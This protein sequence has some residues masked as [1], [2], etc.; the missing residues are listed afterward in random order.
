ML[1]ETNPVSRPGSKPRVCLVGGADIDK[2]LDLMTTL[3]TEYDFVGVGTDTNLAPL[4]AKCGFRFRSYRMSR[5]AAPSSDLLAT[6]QLL[7]IFRSERPAIVHTF[8]TKPGVWGRIAARTAGVPV[9]IGTIPG[10]GSLYSSP[11][12]RGRVIRL[13]YQPLQRFAS[14]VST[15]TVFQ[16]EDDAREFARLGVVAADRTTIVP[17][18][19]VRTDFFSAGV[20]GAR[21]RL[22]SRFGFPNDRVVVLMISRILR[23]KGVLDFAGAA[24]AVTGSHQEALFVLVGPHDP[25]SLDALTPSELRNLRASVRWLGMRDDVKDLLEA[26]D[27][28]VF[29][30]V[31]REGIPRVLLEAASM[32]LPIVG[33]DVPGSREVIHDGKNG[34]LIQ[35]GDRAA[36]SLAIGMLVESQQLRTQ[37]GQ[38]SRQLAVSQFDLGVVAE[39]TR[40]V[41]ERALKA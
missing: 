18:S 19:G 38:C 39:A 7:L 3:A 41:Y 16:N 6:L 15:L 26:A 28:F 24:Q 25:Q 14:R 36:M 1:R 33:M 5:G 34:F 2:R 13:L 23:S 10:L 30:S 17:G 9:V 37:F 29:P 11:S 32:A 8:D 27:I 20:P 35:P 40:S 31:Y 22:R 12:W 21:P 4:F